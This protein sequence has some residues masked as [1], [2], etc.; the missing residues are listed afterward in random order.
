MHTR[1]PLCI[2]VQVGSHMCCTVDSILLLSHQRVNMGGG[3]GNGN[4][5]H[6]GAELVKTAARPHPTCE[7]PHTQQHAGTRSSCTCT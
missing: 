5:S 3:V 2:L 4:D 6:G 1:R 7:A